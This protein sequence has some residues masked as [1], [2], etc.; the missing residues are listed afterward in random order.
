MIDNYFGSV[1]NVVV[2][3]NIL[4]G[5]GFTVYSDGQFNGGTISGVKFT[6][7]RLKKGYYGYASIV[8]NSPTVSGNVDDVTG[9]AISF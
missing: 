6:N 4:R 7:N 5:G 8:K 2:D 3:N 9:N 1:S